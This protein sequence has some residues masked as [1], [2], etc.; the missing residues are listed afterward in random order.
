MI[1]PD[2]IWSLVHMMRKVPQ[3]V[4]PD[5]TLNPTILSA[6]TIQGALPTLFHTPTT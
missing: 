3:R 4:V 5:S 2:L 6:Q 1:D